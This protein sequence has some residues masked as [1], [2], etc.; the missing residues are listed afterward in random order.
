MYTVKVFSFS[1]KVGI[2]F[3][4]FSRI[5]WKERTGQKRFLSLC[6]RSTVQCVQWTPLNA[7]PYLLQPPKL[8]HL[9]SA[10]LRILQPNFVSVNLAQVL[11]SWHDCIMGYSGLLS[12][13]RFHTVN[14]VCLSG[15]DCIRE[16]T[17]STEEEVRHRRPSGEVCPFSFL[18]QF[19]THI[20]V[21]WD[22]E[23]GTKVFRFFSRL[24][25]NRKLQD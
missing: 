9:W 5:R 6:Y 21:H 17:L 3:F 18:V 4:L 11:C 14:L 16:W 22:A 13:Q 19:N 20:H 10:K 25:L 15:T 23:H 8:Q 2:I 12:F 7:E 24:Q 1:P